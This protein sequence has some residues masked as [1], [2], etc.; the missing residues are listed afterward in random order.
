M[1]FWFVSFRERGKFPTFMGVTGRLKNMIPGKD[2]DRL[3][4]GVIPMTMRFLGLQHEMEN[5]RNSPQALSFHLQA[6]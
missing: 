5:Q 2:M 4:T 1:V 3:G 6:S